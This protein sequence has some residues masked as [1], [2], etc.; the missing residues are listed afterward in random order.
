M[1]DRVLRKVWAYFDNAGP[2]VGRPW[3]IAYRG[4]DSERL[5]V[6]RALGV[7]AFPALAY[8]HKA[9]M[10][11]W[12][13]SWTLEFASSYDDVVASATMF[14]EP[15]VADY[16][17]RAID[18]GARVVKVHVQVGGFDPRDPLLDPAWGLLAQTGT[19]VVIHAGSGPAPGAFTG[20][21]PI[22]E[23]LLRHPGLRLVIAHLGMPEIDDFLAIA[24]ENASVHLDTTMAFTDFASGGREAAAALGDRLGP[25]LLALQERIVLGSDFPNIPYPYAHQ[26]AALDRLGLGADWLRAVCWDN[27]A[28]LLGLAP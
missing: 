5:A 15:G 23:I 9:G 22:R 10:A 16:L 25:G 3:P 2:L 18:A 21:E 11:E 28:R 27:G 19:P 7:R 24:R 17:A 26:L 20:P 6:L 1:P 12:L 8:P 13:N 4:T 14:P